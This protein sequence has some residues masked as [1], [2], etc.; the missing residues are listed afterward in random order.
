MSRLL[1]ALLLLLAFTG[2]TPA[3]AQSGIFQDAGKRVAL[4][5]GASDYRHVPAL[6]NPSNDARIIAD[7]LAAL[8][9]DVIRVD[10]PSRSELLEA[11]QAFLDRLDG[12]DIAFFYYAG[13]AIQIGNVN[14]LIPVDAELGTR[15]DVAAN[16]IDLSGIVNEMDARAKTKIVVLDACRD[17]PFEAE[18]AEALA[19]QPDAPAVKR[20]LAVIKRA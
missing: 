17:N 6:A 18:L 5:I 12:S 14:Y 8:R 13:H 10:S 19:G 7:A 1:H 15:D 9:F 4:V 16:F 11:R 3:L 2:A 20:G